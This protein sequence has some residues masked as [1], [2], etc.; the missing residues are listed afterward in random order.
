MINQCSVYDLCGGCSL[1][2]LSP[3][4]YRNLK[5]NYFRETLKSLQ[6]TDSIFSE[7]IFI[8]H[9]TRRRTSISFFNDGHQYVWGYKQEKSHK[10]IS[11]NDCIIVTPEIQRAIPKLA[12]LIKPLVKKDIQVKANITH[13]DNGLDIVLKG[14]KSPKPKELAYFNEQ[15][16]QELPSVIRLMNDNNII[17]QKEIPKIKISDYNMPLPAEVFLQPSNQG[18]EILTHIILKN[19]GKINKKTHILDLFCGLGTFTIPL[20]TQCFVTGYDNTGAAVDMLMENKNYIPCGERLT[21]HKRDLFRDPLSFMELKLFDLLIINP[22]R[23]G[24]EAQ[25]K[26]I[27]QSN[28]KKIIYV[29]CDPKTATQ[30]LQIL[31]QKGFSITSV[32]AIDQFI[33]SKHIEGIAIVTKNKN[34]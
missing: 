4:D 34:I 15:L 22:P 1:Q 20:L 27:A 6:I 24:A 14:L 13:A 2:H 33:Y 5:I 3:I 32:I 21:I 10:I 16:F 11:A 25:I 9:Q 23:A 19:L 12:L 30:D 26:Q 31:T 29:F 18:Q 28:V 8:P 7:P 17:G